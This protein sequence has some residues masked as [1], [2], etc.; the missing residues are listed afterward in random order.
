MTSREAFEA[1]YFGNPITPSHAADKNADGQYKYAAAH[2]A[3]NVWQAA[4]DRAR[5]VAV[6]VLQDEP[7]TDA[8]DCID[9]I[10]EALK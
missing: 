10:K 3:W 2:T 9:A 7:F 1:W 4:T 5:D 8:Q 6:K